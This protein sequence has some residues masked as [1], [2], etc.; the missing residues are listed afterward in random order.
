MIECV[1]NYTNICKEL[2]LKLGT[3]LWYE[4]VPKS[5]EASQGGKV[6]LL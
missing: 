1:L 5:V 2:G 6:I 3:E 4:H